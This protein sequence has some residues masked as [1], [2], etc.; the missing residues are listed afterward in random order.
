ML[1]EE[2]K[3]VYGTQYVARPV[4]IFEGEQNQEWFSKLSP[5][6]RIPIL[7]DHDNGGFQLMEGQA[8]VQYLVRKYDR[9]KPIPQLD[10]LTR[11]NAD[12]VNRLQIQL[13]GREGAV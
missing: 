3:A 7:I 9:G 12:N 1:L 11:H 10:C 6:G 13:Q 4:N 8:I 5:N 2:L